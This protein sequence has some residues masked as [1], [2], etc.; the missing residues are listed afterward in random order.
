MNEAVLLVQ[1]Q[2]AVGV[3][4]IV[5]VL[6]VASYCKVPVAALLDAAKK[7]V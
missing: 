2:V 5:A 7:E 4:L 6:N 3:C 1:Q